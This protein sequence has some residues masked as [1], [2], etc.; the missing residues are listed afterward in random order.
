LFVGAIWALML[1][2][3]IF[4]VLDYGSMVPFW[5]DWNLVPWLTGEQPV[6][7]SWLWEQAGEHR[8]FLP[9]LILVSALKLSGADFRV[10]MYINVLAMAGLGLGFILAARAVRGKTTC[11]DAFFPIVLL[12][13][14]HV[15]SFLWTS[16]NTYV[17]PTVLVG[18]LLILIVVRRGRL[19]PATA[20]LYGL[21]LLGLGL[22]GANGL[23]YVPALASWLAWAGLRYWRDGGWWPARATALVALV[24]ATSAL[25]VVG[26]YFVGFHRISFSPVGYHSTAFLRDLLR[27]IAIFLAMNF[28]VAA[29]PLWRELGPL[30]GGLVIVCGVCLIAA[31]R[32]NRSSERAR[33]FGLLAFLAGCLLLAVA[34]AWGRASWGP[35]SLMLS[36]YASMA[37]PLIC[38]IYFIWETNGPERVRPLGR[39][40]LFILV[41]SLVPLNWSLGQAVASDLAG[42][43]KAL[44][45][46]LQSQMPVHLLV[47]R[48]DRLYPLHDV[49]QNCL[50]S[51]RRAG[52]RSYRNVGENPPFREVALPL[53]ATATHEVDGKGGPGRATGDDS[54]LVFDLPKATLVCGIR[55]RCRVNNRQGMCPYFQ[56]EWR[57]RGR[58]DFTGVRKYVHYM[59]PPDRDGVVLCFTDAR[60]DQIRIRP[61]NQRCEFSIQDITLLL[62][63]DPGRHPAGSADL[64]AGHRQ[65]PRR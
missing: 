53:V 52:F 57:E 65:I 9:K 3:A 39:V 51:L 33:E 29:K 31:I 59:L 63:P 56:V 2:L 21:G 49:M 47:K 45:G 4:L 19:S 16:V 1:I 42:R 46:D 62:P 58:E 22:S 32:R 50:L 15:D 25:S 13:R 48:N 8:F 44:E 23:I 54:Y 55:V 38:G 34:V 5:D 12:H 41:S 30:L 11:A 40:G 18:L 64:A 6:T 28:G 7:I 24:G 37:V 61:D 27:G 20:S 26:L 10:G 60:I 36:R 17:T 43:R 14:G 35:E